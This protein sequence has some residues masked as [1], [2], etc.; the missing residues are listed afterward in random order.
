MSSEVLSAV[1]IIVF[2][3]PLFI[4]YHATVSMWET[5]GNDPVLSVNVQ[6]NQTEHEQL[7]SS[8]VMLL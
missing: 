7:Y 6:L 1:C 8:K 2:P 4:K 3:P 5:N